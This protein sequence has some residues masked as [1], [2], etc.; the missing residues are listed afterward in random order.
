MAST[1]ASSAPCRTGTSATNSGRS[2]ASRRSRRRSLLLGCAAALPAVFVTYYLLHWG[3]G[4]NSRRSGWPT[5]VGVGAAVYRMGRKRLLPLEENRVSRGIYA[6][7]RP[8]LRWTMNH[9][10]AFLTV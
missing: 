3:L 2:R 4:T 10:A 6:F 5:A 7:F 9:K 1:S 8:L